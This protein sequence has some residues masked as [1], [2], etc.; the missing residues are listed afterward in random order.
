[1]N[2]AYI[3][4]IGNAPSI[5]NLPDVGRVKIT[6]IKDTINVIINKDIEG[7]GDHDAV[8]SENNVTIEVK[9]GSTLYVTSNIGDGVDGGETRFIDSK[10]ACITTKCGERGVK[11]NA[12][13]IGPEAEINAS[14]IDGYITDLTD[15]EYTTFDGIFIAKGNVLNHTVGLVTYPDGMTDKDEKEAYAKT[16]GF[17]DVFARNGKASK[18]MFGTTDTELKGIAIIG[19]LGAVIKIDEGNAKHLHVNNLLMDAV[20]QVSN[21]EEQYK[22][23]PYNSDPIEY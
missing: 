13:V 20:N 8:K 23:V 1:M 5:A 2:N 9:G 18:G 17:A 11:G 10:G 16:V 15:P 7:D 21:V 22:A 12:I 4:T 3:E 19:S 6:A 14:A